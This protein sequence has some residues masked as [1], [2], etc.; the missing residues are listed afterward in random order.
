MPSHVEAN[1]INIRSLEIPAF[2]YI[3]MYFI[4]L[5][6]LASLS[7]DNLKKIITVIINIL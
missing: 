6:I 2:S 3:L 7:K 4:A 5:A 1:L